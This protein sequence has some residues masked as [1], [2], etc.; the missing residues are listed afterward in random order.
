MMEID[1]SLRFLQPFAI[2]P[3]VLLQTRLA[4]AYEERKIPVLFM[5]FES[6]RTPHRQDKLRRDPA[7]VTS[8]GPWQSAHNFG[9]AV[10][11]VP[12][13]FTGRVG[14]SWDDNEPWDE[15]TNMAK[16]CGLRQPIQW[17][18]PHIVHPAFDKI[19]RVVREY[20]VETPTAP[21]K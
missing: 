3:F 18:R 10:D 14:W 19:M 15:L 17:D 16:V 7:K 13:H 12:Y 8:A 5:P 2:A 4:Q 6:Y 11:F 9:L 21:V 1:N 20:P